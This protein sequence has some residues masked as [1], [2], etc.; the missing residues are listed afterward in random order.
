VFF[1]NKKM[2]VPQNLAAPFSVGA[3]GPRLK[4]Q[5]SFQTISGGAKHDMT[6]HPD[7]PVKIP[8]PRR[9]EINEYIAKQIL[10]Y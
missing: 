1:R 7:K 2:T 10:S 8:I 3:E 4:K 5:F 9:T 6:K